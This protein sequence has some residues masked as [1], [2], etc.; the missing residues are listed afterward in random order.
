MLRLVL[1]LL[2]GLV[3][4]QAASAQV[5]PNYPGRGEFYGGRYTEHYRPSPYAPHGY[6]GSYRG[7]GGS[8]YYHP[9]VRYDW[10]WGGGN[11]GYLGGR[12]GGWG[13]EW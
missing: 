4:I 2:I 8:P 5:W 6:Y 3:T 7:Y 11:R 12:G 13:G 1:A 9:P 10:S